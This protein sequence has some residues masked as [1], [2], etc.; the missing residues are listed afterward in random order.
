MV[1]KD[2]FKLSSATAT[3][4]VIVLSFASIVTLWL[5][6]AGRIDDLNDAREQV[7][8]LR[9]SWGNLEREMLELPARASSDVNAVKS[10]YSLVIF[11]VRLNSFLKSPLADKLS[12]FSGS[13]TKRFNDLN[14]EWLV[15]RQEFESRYVMTSGSNSLSESELSTSRL[16]FSVLL[17]GL[18]DTI[19]DKIIQQTVQVRLIVFTL[20]IIIVVAVIFFINQA[21][22]KIWPRQFE[23][24]RLASQRTTEIE[25]AKTAAQTAKLQAEQINRQLQASVN[26][27]NLMTMQAMETGQSKNELMANI[28]R[29]IRIPMNAIVG[30]SEM[31]AEENLTDQQ[32]K[33]VS[34]IHESCWQLL[35]LVNDILDYSKIETGRL[36]IE[37]ADC[38]VENILNSVESIMRPAA[39][40]KK[41]QLEIIR[42]K[43]LPE[44][45]RTDSTRLKQCLM[46]LINNAIESTDRGSVSVRVSQISDKSLIRFDIEDMG[47]AIPSEK[48]NRIFEPFS[49]VNNGSARRSGSNG[50]RLAIARHLS[51][52]LGGSVTAAST[53]DRGSVFTLLLPFS[54]PPAQTARSNSINIANR[55]VSVSADKVRFAGRVLVAE[56]TPTNQILISLLLK[57]L[58]LEAVIVENGQQAVQKAMTEKF[59]VI[60]MDIQMPEMNGYDATQQLRKKGV[61]LPII[62]QTAC[63]MKGDDE[64]CLAAGCSDYI[65]KPID[66]KK[67]VDI[68][69]KY[70]P[71]ENIIPAAKTAGFEPQKGMVQKVPVPPGTGE[72]E[73]DWQLLV[74]RIGNEELIGEI[75]PIFVK[76]NEERMKMLEKAVAENDDREVK[77]YAH[78]IKGASGT[79]GA[80]AI[81]DLARQLENAARDL[82]KS[83]Y[84]PLFE[85]LKARFG[86]LAEFL[87]QSDWKQIASSRQHTKKA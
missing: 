76:D 65:S 51:E 68:L 81:S 49:Q 19:S 63:A 20:S 80:V 6:T 83:K 26:H 50:L 40:E 67:L 27:A 57:K 7:R 30:F 48:L 14:T 85:E 70:L 84:N 24:E 8:I 44:F 61:I 5:F 78:S 45:I 1:N 21:H 71:V 10:A 33:Q 46:N 43:P 41:L 17:E 72:I 29:E 62:A 3:I 59:D 38:S 18:S 87:S 60:L 12:Q 37:A 39:A 79:I 31:L 55:P 56:D 32:K 53:A 15:L 82:D 11:D 64:K 9:G 47:A 34:I 74:E 42:N 58:G 35:Q 86:R 2:I 54:I 25:E 23:L 22:K 77:F 16:R 13:F 66:K 52:I 75:I 73:I 69:A 36:E 28:S 4:F